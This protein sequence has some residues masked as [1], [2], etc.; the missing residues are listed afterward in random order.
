[1]IDSKTEKKDTK[2]DSEDRTEDGA[3]TKGSEEGTRETE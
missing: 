1:M 2:R 3:W